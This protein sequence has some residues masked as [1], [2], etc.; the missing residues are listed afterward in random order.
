MTSS[1]VEPCTFED[2][3]V[4][5]EKNVQQDVRSQWVLNA[6]E[7]PS[8]WHVALDSFRKTVSNYREKTSS[9]S[10]QSCGTLLLSVL[11]VVFP[12]LVWGRSYTVAKFR[13][14]FLAGLT[15]ASLCIP[16]SIGYATLANLAPQYGLYTSVVPPLI[17]AVMGTS[18]EIA[19]GP[20]AVVSLLLSSMVQKLVDPSTDPIGYTKLIFL[21]TLF[22]GIFQ[23]SFGLFRLGF[24]VDFLSHAAIVGF[25]AGAAIVIGLQQLK[26]LFG[27][28]HFTTKTDIISVLKAVWEAFHNPWNPHNFILG[29]SFLVFI[30]TTRFVGKR[31]KKLFWLASIAPLVSVI[32][33]TL[34]VFLTRADKNGVKIVKH[35][36]GGLNPSSINQLDFN[37][38]HVVDVAKIGL[39][40]AVVALTESV[41]VGRSFASIK[42][43]Q[44]DGNKE[45]MSI[46][47]TNIIGSLTS[48]YVATGSFSRTAVNYAA[49]CESLISNIVMAI[50]VMISLQFLTNLLYY[51][52]IA[53]IASVILS[54]LPGLIDINEAYKIW[55]VDKLDFL[56]CAGAFFGVLFASV[57]IGLLVAVV[58]SFAKIIVI[59]IR[60]S[61]ETLGKLPGTDLFCDVDQYPMAIQIPGVMII[62]MKSALLCFANA[63]FV[64]ERIIKWVTQKG[65][66]D[67]K[68]NSKSTI[69]L[70]I[71][72]TS[73]L[74]NIDT[75]G[76]ASM[77]ELYKCLSTHGKQLAIANPRWQVIHKLKVSNFV[78]KIGGRVYLTV[79]EAVASCK[80]NHF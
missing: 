7:P 20:V 42:G 3:Q 31:K 18:R 12:I 5:L 10:D 19:I 2:M 43:Y 17:Y 33:S 76:I 60:P 15:I 70:V 47:F 57:E 13:K 36:K 73:N 77:E 45:M 71:L 63:N 37:S 35:V 23:T 24:L 74:V 44:L 69:Q 72:D 61:T 28:T 53:I 55:K 21:A 67:D 11:H 22:A 59:S 58:I 39:I 64:K 26:G 38:P 41:A 32:L 14:D 50:T 16:Q 1:V 51:T 75:S 80:S 46:G 49:G 8:P 4:D 29:G 27:I 65:L 25:V 54:A 78:S 79:E 48:C 66:E 6:P 56:A 52:P 34:V 30:L 40:V 68:G 62:R 9:L